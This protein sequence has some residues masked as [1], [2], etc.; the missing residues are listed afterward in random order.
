MSDD[1]AGDRSQKTVAEL[2]ALHGGAEG[3]SRRRRRR[4]AEEEETDDAPRAERDISDTAPQAIIDRIKGEGGADQQPERT[5]ADQDHRQS[6][7]GRR[8]T[9]QQPPT[10]PAQTAPA[11]RAQPAQDHQHPQSPPPPQQPSRP[12]PRPGPPAHGH[13]NPQPQQRP[14]PAP[15]SN[16][17]NF[18][19]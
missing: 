9:A 7:V 18:L 16:G 8:P 4:A 15:E 12:L 13:A 10:H 19:A 2:L 1:N 14:E 3:S 17:P 5:S 11:S 6:R